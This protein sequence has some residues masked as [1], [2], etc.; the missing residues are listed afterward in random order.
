MVNTFDFPPNFAADQIFENALAE[1]VASG[2]TIV[3]NRATTC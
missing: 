3:F 2:N 1:N